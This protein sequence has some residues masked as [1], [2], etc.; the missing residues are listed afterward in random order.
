MWYWDK[1]AERNATKR[2]KG[3]VSSRIWK[4][5]EHTSTSFVA[6]TSWIPSAPTEDRPWELS[7]SL[8][9]TPTPV[10]VI[11]PDMYLSRVFTLLL[12]CSYPGPIT[13]ISLFVHCPCIT[14]D[15][16]FLYKTM[17]GFERN[18]KKEISYW[19][20]LLYVYVEYTNIRCVCA[21]RCEEAN[22][23]LTA[24]SSQTYNECNRWNLAGL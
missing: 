21:V 18:S 7:L 15:S 4:K 24:W 9:I 3:R 11:H 1:L 2:G 14:S 22:D 6:A 5:E 20:L 16:I 12:R 13:K 8:W 23:T 17:G 10:I 19:I